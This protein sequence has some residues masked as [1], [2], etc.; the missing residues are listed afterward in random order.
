MLFFFLILFWLPW[1]KDLSCSCNLHHSCSNARSFNPLC[2][3]SDR[4]CILVLRRHYLSH[5]TTVRLP[6]VTHSFSG[7]G[8]CICPIGCK[9]IFVWVLWRKSPVFKC[10][11]S[12]E[13]F[14]FLHYTLWDTTFLA[15]VNFMVL[16][17]CN[18]TGHTFFTLKL[19]F[20]KAS[21]KFPRNFS[22]LDLGP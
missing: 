20:R 5:C 2:Q 4:I 19:T 15:Q 11:L 13:D 7:S 22:N 9:L 21:S 14:P 17:F 10:L 1:A 8:P 18:H 12:K 3:A 6:R 16:I